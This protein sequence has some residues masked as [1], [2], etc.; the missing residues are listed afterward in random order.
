MAAKRANYKRGGERK[1]KGKNKPWLPARALFSGS[2]V[3]LLYSTSAVMTSMSIGAKGY[4]GFPKNSRGSGS[5]E[6]GT[7]SRTFSW[8]PKMLCLN[9]NT[10]SHKKKSALCPY[11]SLPPWPPY[12]YPLESEGRTPHP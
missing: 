9:T 2:F 3:T 8:S 7:S 1:K 12:H 6:S 5:K 11:G 10:H 4:L